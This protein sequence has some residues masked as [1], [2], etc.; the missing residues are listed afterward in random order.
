MHV[1]TQNSRMESMSDYFLGETVRSLDLLRKIDGTVDSLVLMRRQMDAFSEAVDGLLKTVLQASKGIFS[2]DEIIPPLEQSQDALKRI[3]ERLCG[4]QFSAR[5]TPEL[6]P[7]DG[8]DDAYGQ[9][10]LAVEAFSAKIETLRWSI[11][12]HNA[13]VEGKSQELLLSTDDDIDRFFDN[14]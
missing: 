1:I 3:H 11:L 13:D 8:V 5:R 2:E 14:L 7:E 6:C 10:I 9:A 12:E 4:G